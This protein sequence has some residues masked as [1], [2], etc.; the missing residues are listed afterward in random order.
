MGKKQ[1]AGWLLIAMAA[2]ISAGIVTT[3]VVDLVGTQHPEVSETLPV[4]G[5]EPVPEN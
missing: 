2:A 3:E 5:F 1:K 4:I